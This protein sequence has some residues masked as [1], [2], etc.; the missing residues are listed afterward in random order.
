TPAPT[1]ADHLRARLD[2]YY[3][4]LRELEPQR[5]FEAPG[6]V[7]RPDVSYLS[8]LLATTER[9][10]DIVW[11]GGRFRPVADDFEQLQTVTDRTRGLQ[12]FVVLLAR[13]ARCHSIPL[14]L[15]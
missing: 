5:A 2:A 3:H 11:P 10:A 8:L 14:M 9:A 4:L 1:D 7:P 6:P 15:T 12:D 13:N